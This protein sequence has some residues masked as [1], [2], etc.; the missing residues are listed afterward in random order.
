M[1]FSKRV[2]SFFLLPKKK[3][4]WWVS[5]W[6]ESKEFRKQLVAV[7]LEFGIGEILWGFHCY[8]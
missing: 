7:V 4:N 1:S 8:D 2:R 5:N 6:R 3:L